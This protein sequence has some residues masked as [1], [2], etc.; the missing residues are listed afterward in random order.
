MICTFFSNVSRHHDNVEL[1]PEFE[2]FLERAY[3]NNAG[4]QLKSP[5]NHPAQ[6]CG[7]VRGF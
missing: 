2:L 1:L 4:T 7:D 6:Y 5:L 3:R